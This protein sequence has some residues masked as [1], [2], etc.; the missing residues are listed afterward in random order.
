MHIIPRMVVGLDIDGT[1]TAAP[2]FF[3]ML[4]KAVYREGGKVLIISART[5][6]SAVREH[7]EAE[8][9]GYGVIYSKLILLPTG[10]EMLGEA[11][12]QLDWLE[13]FL[14]QKVHISVCEHVQCFFDDDPTVIDLFTRYAPW[15]QIYQ[16]IVPEN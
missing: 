5:K 2:E 14:W 13:R 12:K 16:S 9:R 6:S 15:V 1:I 11:P 4:T 7:T 3:S 10:E 8:L